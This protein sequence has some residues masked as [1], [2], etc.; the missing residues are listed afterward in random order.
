MSRRLVHFRHVARRPSG[1]AFF[2]ILALGVLGLTGLARAE[3]KEGLVDLGKADARLKGYHANRGFKA[4]VIAAEP[5]IVDPVAMAFDDLG[6]LF[7]AEWKPADHAIETLETLAL[8]EGGTTRV[9]RSRKS[10]TDVV[11]R[12]KDS[13]GD[14]VYESSEVVLDGCEMPTSILPW[15]NSLLLTCVGRL[16]RWSDE[17]GDGKF[18]TR[19]ILADGFAAMDRRGLSGITLGADGWLYLTSG[20]DDNHV[21]GTDGSRVDLSRTGGVFRARVDGSRFQLFAMGLRN[22]YRGLAFDDG[23]DPFLLDGDYPD[24]SKF[25]GVRLVN[26]VEDG[27]YGWRLRPG[28]PSGPADFDRAAAN[29][30]RPGKL[31]VVAKLGRGSPSGLVV[32]NGVAFPE[33]L[34][35]T[36]IE[37]DPSRHAVRGY[38]VESKGG[39]HALKGELTLM[40]ADDEQFRPCQVV[41]GADGAIYV[42]DHRGRGPD[43][44]QPWGEGKAGRLYRLTW[45]GDGV[46]PA[47][48]SKP[49]NWQR[50]FQATFDQLVF[51]YM[52]SPDAPES[53]R[54]TRE[55]LD[56]GVAAV[57]PCLGWAT[58]T[59]ASLHTRLL[60]IQGARQLWTDP[61]VEPTMVSLL[62]DPQADVRRL[63]AQAIAWEP[64]AAIPRLVPKLLPHLD[65]ADP[66][67]VRE[68]VLAIG[69]HSEPNPQ[70]TAA[71]LLRWLYAH[72]QADVT[73]KDAFL[74][75]LEKLGDA[76]VE[77]VALAIRT[78][79][80]VERE[81][82]VA[83]F[84]ALRTAPAAE[85]LAGLVKIP[86]LSGPERVSLV[87]QFQ[88]IPLNIPVPTQGLADWVAKHPEVEPEVKIAALDA[89]RLAGNPASTMVLGLLDDEDEAVRL[90]ATRLAAQFRPPGAIEKLAR[91][92]KEKEASAD[93]RLA[94]VKALRVAGLK[95]FAALEAAYLDSEDPA[96][97][98]VV[99]RSMAEADRAKAIPALESALAGP[100]LVLKGEAARLLG[101]SPRT[102]G[103]LAQAYLNR[104]IGRAEL[105]VVLASLRKYETAEARKL[106]A[107]IE[108]DAT[109]GSGALGAAEVR[110][111]L[112]QADPWAGLGIFFRE[113]SQCSTCHKVEARGVAFGPPLTLAASS[114]TPEKLIDSI[115]FPDR[116]IRERY[117]SKKVVLK[118][119]R[120][121]TGIVAGKDAKA[122]TLREQDGRE[123][124]IAAEAID[125]EVREE[126]SSMP[127]NIS[128]DLT[129]DELADL[130]AFL[131]SKPAQASLKHG[132][133]RLDRV[134]TIGPF[135]LGADRLRVP[136]DRI[137]PAKPLV[138][139]DGA[140]LTWVAQEANGWG[141]L[142][143]GGEFRSK[144]GRAYLA[145]QVRST[146]DQ[147]GALRFGVEGASRI[148]LNGTRVA[149]V[150]DR[151]PAALVHAF[152]QPKPGC[153]ATLPELVRLPLKAGANLLI[154][155]LDH[156]GAG[157]ARAAF[158]IASPE[159]V[160]VRTPK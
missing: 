120:V 33:W 85:Q 133:K 128:L 20:D 81:S 122:L 158:E 89:C 108:E 100:D 107:V 95:A 147:V 21:V 64:K 71:V 111:K 48:A 75:A 98:K 2:A 55:L 80:G 157:D 65:D 140:T 124:R 150:P 156:G 87:R 1:L 43:D 143:L 152:A 109:R 90:A 115:L 74:R 93:E 88:D 30:E 148:Y 129:P 42:L 16:E 44:S 9:R 144:P 38:K 45:E 36:L 136:L 49:N 149:D 132:P 40:T 22:P 59:A 105:P 41:V 25:Q 19:S 35:E 104:T 17:D 58:N 134:L 13:D 6:N 14:G 4:R 34:R 5:A 51:Q 54:A 78:R 96:F 117:E 139:Q 26:P 76:G 57:G 53:E 61:Q 159:P 110:G 70:K 29:G 32:Y 154:I 153:L 7:V 46:S 69:R 50:L 10:T 141:T 94:I 102:I 8:P 142:N 47:L 131:Q 116:E 97:R 39:A 151:E 27:D 12:L 99:L 155:A 130:V 63:A 37:P 84:A 73:L 67:V 145:V 138:G 3:G 31:P 113:S 103:L 101:E 112:A 15:K 72:P 137:D 62:G 91:R 125:R 60:G 126:D 52:A 82:A 24:G 28:F 92:L 83:F 66:R 77:E 79:R 146:K 106:L 18:E 86:D 23:F 123:Y 119:G 68:V 160:E 11:K 135:D 127:A 56:R 121:L 118:D 114:P